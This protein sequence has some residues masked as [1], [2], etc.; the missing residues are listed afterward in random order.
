M[1]TINFVK[2]KSGIL[3]AAHGLVNEKQDLEDQDLAGQEIEN[4]GQEKG[5]TKLPRTSHFFMGE[6]EFFG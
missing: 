5:K 1:I 6:V 4:R 2:F 3:T